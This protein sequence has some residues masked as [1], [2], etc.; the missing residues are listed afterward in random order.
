[1]AVRRRVIQRR[2]SLRIRLVNPRSALEEALG[3]LGVDRLR[4][5]MDRAVARPVWRVDVGAVA[6]EE[7]D[8]VRD[9]CHLGFVGVDFA[10][11][12]GEVQ[13]TAA[14]VVGGIDVLCWEE[15]LKEI[16]L[17]LLTC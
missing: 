1:M 14:M 11:A 16:Y 17:T 5:V 15:L 9:V 10:A 7:A 6:E 12:E 13:R 3:G 4:T 2:A 8:C